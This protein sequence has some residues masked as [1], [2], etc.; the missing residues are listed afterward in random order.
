MPRVKL[1]DG[2]VRLV[3]PPFSGKLSGFTLLFEAL[4]LSERPAIPPVPPVI[5]R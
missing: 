1:L 2:S 5:G 4:V 3:K